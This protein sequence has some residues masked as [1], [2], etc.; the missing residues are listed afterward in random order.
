MAFSWVFALLPCVFYQFND[1]QRC[2]SFGDDVSVHVAV[3][4]LFTLGERCPMAIAMIPK[5][6]G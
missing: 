2:E 6:S 5:W 3:N 4:R 1:A